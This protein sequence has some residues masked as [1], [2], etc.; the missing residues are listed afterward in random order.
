[1]RFFRSRA[2]PAGSP[3]AVLSPTEPSEQRS[4]PQVSSSPADPSAEPSGTVSEPEPIPTPQPEVTSGPAPEPERE[5][6]REAPPGEPRVGA[7]TSRSLGVPQ[8]WNLWELERVAREQSGADAARDEERSFLLIYLRE[9]ADADGVLP[10][11]FDTIVR[12]SFGDV[13]DAVG[14]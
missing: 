8:R 7:F 14:A 2:R 6:Q 13:L 3:D 12:E 5:P 4:E 9:F 10:T 1:M 11:S